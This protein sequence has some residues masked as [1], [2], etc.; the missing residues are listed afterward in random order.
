MSEKVVIPAHSNGAVAGT[1][2]PGGM[3]WNGL[4]FTGCTAMRPAT[5]SKKSHRFFERP[6]ARR[7]T[8]SDLSG[9]GWRLSGST[10]SPNRMSSGSC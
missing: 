3:L 9:S 2:A 7:A 8:D 1:S 10:F 6:R 5:P 4:T